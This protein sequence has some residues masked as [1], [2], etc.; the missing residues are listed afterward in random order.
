MRDAFDE[1]LNGQKIMSEFLSSPL[2]T[3]ELADK[4]I[5][6]NKDYRGFEN[7]AEEIQFRTK[8][9]DRNISRLKVNLSEGAD[10][11]TME[12]HFK[13]L[14]SKKMFWK[15]A[16]TILPEDSSVVSASKKYNDF[17]KTVGSFEEV[18]T[19]SKAFQNEKL[20]SKTMPS[21]VIRDAKIESIFKTAFNNESK[22][23]NW[24]RTLLKVNITDRGWTIIR[25]KLTGAI[26]GR[27]HFAAIVFKDNKKGTC[28]LYINY[29]IYQQYNG[30]GYNS[31][32]TGKS[33]MASDDFLCENI[34]K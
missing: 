30:S 16:A 17:S 1:K 27:K 14:N 29:H 24:D 21:A 22:S 6:A 12:S 23:T 5:A 13:D 33:N 28:R 34:N 25:N 3:Q 20:A 4:V 8:S 32:A 9:V 18:K 11:D 19:T 10:Y 26:L 15:T 31:F 7:D 2:I